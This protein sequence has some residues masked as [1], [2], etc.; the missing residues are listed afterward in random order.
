MYEQHVRT[1]TDAYK[2]GV[3][4]SDEPVVSLFGT[5][6]SALFS[7]QISSTFPES[8]FLLFHVKQLMHSAVISGGKLGSL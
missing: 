5:E 6:L 4:A 3:W 2:G 8:C 1:Q 7:R